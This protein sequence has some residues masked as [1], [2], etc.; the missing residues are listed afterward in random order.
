MGA[1]VIPVCGIPI[2]WTLTS[3]PMGS[4]MTFILSNFPLDKFCAFVRDQVSVS[5]GI[6]SFALV[7]SF[8][9]SAKFGFCNVPT[10]A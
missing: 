2:D 8:R 4:D 5:L 7:V 6:F 10:L 9:R 1:A 3:S